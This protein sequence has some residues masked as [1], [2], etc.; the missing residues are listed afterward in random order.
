MFENAL[1]VVK[2]ISK[3]GLGLV[4][5]GDGGGRLLDGSCSCFF[6]SVSPVPTLS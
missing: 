2:R 3:H 6:E 4:M 1:K 5:G